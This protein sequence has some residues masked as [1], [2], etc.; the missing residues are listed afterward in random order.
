MHAAMDVGAVHLGRSGGWLDHRMRLLA[1][2]GAIQIHQ[3]LAVD[4]LLE[5]REILADA[6][7][8]KLADVLVSVLMKF[9]QETSVPAESRSGP[10]LMRS[11]M[12]LREGVRSAGCAPVLADA[13]RL[14][15]EERF[16]VELADGRA[17]RAAHI[18]GEES[19]APAWC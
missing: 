17:V 14:Q 9:L 10:T 3:R 7:T 8:S 18:V 2:G 4:R 16:R 19:A 12:S 15:V 13:A 11:T 1:G 6:S 5:D